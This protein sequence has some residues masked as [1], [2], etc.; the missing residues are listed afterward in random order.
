MTD[1]SITFQIAAAV[2]ALLVV[3]ALVRI[4][5]AAVLPLLRNR[6]LARRGF[7]SEPAYQRGGRGIVS[8]LFKLV[9]ALAI[10]AIL[11]AIAIPAYQDYARRGHATGSAWPTSR[12][13]R[14]LSTPIAST[15]A[16]IPSARP[17]PS[18]RRASPPR[19]ASWS[20]TAI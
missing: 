19:W 20:P 5:V 9:P 16:P 17:K 2:V 3:I 11:A 18:I 4:Y 10:L 7:S 8:L 12:S 1:A 15:T 6:R 14:P 13:F